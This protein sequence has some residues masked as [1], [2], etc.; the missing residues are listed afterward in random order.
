M[1]DETT[2]IEAPAPPSAVVLFGNT[3]PQMKV[4]IPLPDATPEELA[5][6]RG[7]RMISVPAKHIS[8]SE[9]RIELQ[10]DILDEEFVNHTLS[11]DNDR[12][13]W[14]I[15]KSL[16]DQHKKYAIAVQHMEHVIDEH[17]AG[18]K[19]AWVDSSNS[20][21]AQALGEFYGIPVGQPTMMLMLNGRDKLHDQHMSTSAQPASFN[22]IALTAS[23][24]TIVNSSTALAGEIATGGGGLV[25]KQV[26]YAHTAGTN[27]STLTG[28]FTANGSDVLPVVVAQI[29]VFNASSSVTMGYNTSLSS[30]STLTVSGDST[31]VT[32]TDTAG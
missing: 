8:Q 30:T 29:G 22:Y 9:T 20:E 19:P 21:L 2:T 12:V 31:T 26:T 10:P 11:T 23:T 25:R 32:W 28:T 27:T 3:A 7:M 14:M 18:A 15:A 24:T 17:A 13:L 16:P 1:I 4:R 6:G 5:E